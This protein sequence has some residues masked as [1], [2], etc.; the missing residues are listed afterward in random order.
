M[1]TTT[2]KPMNDLLSAMAVSDALVYL[3]DATGNTIFVSDQLKLW[4]Q[5]DTQLL[6]SEGIIKRADRHWTV[7]HHN[8]PNGQIARI[9]CPKEPDDRALLEKS[10]ILEAL[11]EAAPVAILTLDL[12]MRV[13]MW[14]PACE[15][16]FGWSEREVLGQPYPLVP[17]D[18]WSRFEGFYKT[19]IEGQGFTGVEAERTR[20]DGKRIF[21]AISTAPIRRGNNEIVGAMAV[22]EEITERK[23]LEARVE[24]SARLES[25][26]RFAGGVAHD[27][28]NILTVILSY[29]ETLLEQPNATMVSQAGEA[30]QHSCTQATALT[31]QLLAFSKRQVMRVETVDLNAVILATV[32]ML[33]RLIGTDI[34]IRTDLTANE[35]W[36]QADPSMI[37]QVIMNLAT[38]ARD[39]MPN[40]GQLSLS[41]VRR[42]VDGAPWIQLSVADTG[43]G[44]D[45]QTIARIFEPFFTTKPAEKGSGLGLASVHGIVQQ[46]GGEVDVASN[47]GAGTTVYITIPVSGA[48][49]QSGRDLDSPVPI[50]IGATILLVEDNQQV[51]DMLINMLQVNEN[52]V[53]SAGDG[54]EALEI[55][56][57]YDGKID[58][59]LTDV[60]MPRMGGGELARRLRRL[61]P[62]TK[63]ILMSGYA[64]EELATQGMEAADHF[65]HKPFRSSQ[66]REIIDKALR[67]VERAV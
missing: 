51:R 20:K 15:K 44:M 5:S 9:V 18:E 64:D 53:L 23:Q 47:L 24:Q 55:A 41:T 65:L 39:A 11:V 7:R 35:A 3:T 6:S 17:E 14:N 33:D 25:I 34:I 8:L 52:R 2:T 28:N 32:S 45:Q 63:I 31:Q 27:F 54:I 19:V 37:E 60:V 49:A 12:D 67:T 1:K 66:V 42:Q 38:N 22:L 16:I 4:L 26:G 36:I 48:P 62:A 43:C 29:A 58:L 61:R 50:S 59:L 10:H 21:T 57:A 13:T 56:S 30:I 40:G 46:S